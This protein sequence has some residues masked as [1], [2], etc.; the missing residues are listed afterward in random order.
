MAPPEEA[1]T[2][3]RQPASALA[4]RR[5]TVRSTVSIA[6][7]AGSG[8]ARETPPWAARCRIASRLQRA[9]AAVVAGLLRS[10]ASTSTFDGS[11][12]PHAWRLSSTTRT[13]R[14]S[15]TSRRT[16]CTPMKPAP[17]VTR[18]RL[19]T[20]PTLPS[21]RGGGNCEVQTLGTRRGADR[22]DD[23]LAVLPAARGPSGRAGGNVGQRFPGAG[24]ARRARGLWLHRGAGL[25]LPAAAGQWTAAPDADHPGGDAQQLGRQPDPAGA[26]RGCGLRDAGA[27]APQG[28]GGRRGGS[29]RAE[30]AA[31]P[32][33]PAAGCADHRAARRRD[34]AARP[35]RRRRRPGVADR[36]RVDGALLEPAAWRD[37][38]LAGATVAARI[39][40]R[41]T[42]FRHRG[43]RLRQPPGASGRGHRGGAGRHRPAVLRPLC[44][45]RPGP[46]LAA[47]LV[48]A[49]HSHPPA[50]GADSGSRRLWH[51]AGVVDGGPDL[52]RLVGR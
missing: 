36:R 1:K 17:P 22:G 43:T 38:R 51:H 23:R 5:A 34:P 13:V 24:P 4:L 8:T 9:T 3:R 48:R 25:P 40:A 49:Q 31:R 29:G 41:A 46:L 44:R 33:E 39:A 52:A 18:M 15:A 14:S 12:S 37:R 28:P 32:G 35:A 11:D 26:E 21:P 6:S 30:P 10:A 50:G 19:V 16:V 47:G 45:H 27:H 7:P 2:K 20:T 42:P